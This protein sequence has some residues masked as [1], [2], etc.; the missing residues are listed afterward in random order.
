MVMADSMFRKPAPGLRLDGMSAQSS[1]WKWSAVGGWVD[2]LRVG[3]CKFPTFNSNGL[4]GR[5][6]SFIICFSI[7]SGSLSFF[8]IVRVK[9][10]T[11]VVA[12]GRLGEKGVKKDHGLSAPWSENY[13]CI[14]SVNRRTP[15]RQ[16][17]TAAGIIANAN[18]GQSCFYHS[19]RLLSEYGRTAKVYHGF[20]VESRF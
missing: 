11:T 4:I 1:G 18:I 19:V 9:K 2:R 20:F 8:K 13:A 17:K 15:R 10:T 3:R 5:V 6:G 7:F 16:I 14:N 12:H